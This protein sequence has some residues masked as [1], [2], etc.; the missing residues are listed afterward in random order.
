MVVPALS[1]HNFDILKILYILFRLEVE[2][3][4]FTNFVRW[5]DKFCIS[6]QDIVILLFG[7]I[8][9]F[10]FDMCLFTFL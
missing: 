5:A 1:Q 9:Y 6:K 10:L 2:S 8:N 3:V 4:V 7:H